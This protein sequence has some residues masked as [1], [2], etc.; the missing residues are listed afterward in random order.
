MLYPSKE[1]YSFIFL[2]INIYDIPLWAWHDAE[3][4]DKG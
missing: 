4:G 3:F 2:F 1:D